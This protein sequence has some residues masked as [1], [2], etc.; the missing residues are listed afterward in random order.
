MVAVACPGG[1]KV[2]E[3]VVPPG[4]AKLGGCRWVSS[5]YLAA[6]LWLIRFHLQSIIQMMFCRLE[7][8]DKMGVEIDEKYANELM[9]RYQALLMT[10]G[11][12]TSTAVEGKPKSGAY[13]GH[14]IIITH[15]GDRAED[16]RELIL[17]QDEVAVFRWVSE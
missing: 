1:S 3:V 12:R 15:D 11:V 8:K 16:I 2:L 9:K 5:R 14:Q 17:E 4:S 6:D 7:E 10:A 13:R